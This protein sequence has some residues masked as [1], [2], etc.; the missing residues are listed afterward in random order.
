MRTKIRGVKARPRLVVYRTNKN[1]S[2]QIVNDEAH[3]TML[4]ARTKGKTIEVARALGEKFAKE[5]LEKG[6]KT[7]VFDRSGY[8]YHGAIQALADALRKGGVQF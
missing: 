1:M 4:S 3:T 5:M 2:V 6:V 8:R 7:I